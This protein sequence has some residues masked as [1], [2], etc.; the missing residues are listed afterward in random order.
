MSPTLINSGLA[1]A[2]L[3]G[4]AA[5]VVYLALEPFTRRTWP[6]SLTSWNRL[7]SG[8]FADPL[9]GR[10]LLI[11]V[12]GTSL[13]FGVMGAVGSWE[14][15]SGGS[16]RWS[17]PHGWSPLYGPLSCLTNAFSFMT[18]LVGFGV[19]SL[20]TIARKLIRS[21]RWAVVAVAGLLIAIQTRPESLSLFLGGAALLGFAV[22]SAAR[23]GFLSTLTVFFT[24]LNVSLVPDALDP[25]IWWARNSWVSLAAVIGVALWG[26][27]TATRGEMA[28]ARTSTYDS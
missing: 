27:Q 14:L 24:T 12:G 26:Y 15:A 20:L 1:G 8:R 5:W 2:C 17:F 23:F 19:M 10:D 4:L 9:V 11:G 16:L 22:F 28:P 3:V 25:S 6:R 21:D 13:L 18:V 7:L